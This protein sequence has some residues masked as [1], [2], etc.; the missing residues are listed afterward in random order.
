MVYAVIAILCFGVLIATHE[1]GHMF[2]AKACGVKVNE[3]AI[4]MGP[5]LWSKQKGETK[6]S[7]RLFPVGGYCAIEGESGESDDPRSLCSQSVLKQIFVFSAGV[8]VNFLTGFLILV[9]IYAGADFLITPEIVS[10][11]DGFPYAGEAG[12]MVGDTIKE[13][14]GSSVYLYSD[15]SVILMATDAGPN[16]RISMVVERDGELLE[17]QL[18]KTTYTEADGSETVAYG[19]VYGG[20]TPATLDMKLKY[21]FLNTIDFVRL[22]GFNFKIIAKGTAGVDDLRGPVGI[23]SE[24]TKMGNEAEATS[25]FADAFADVLYYVAMIAINL[26]VMNLLPIPALDGGHIVVLLLDTVVMKLFSR[27][28]SQKAINAVTLGSFAL[29]LLLMLVISYQD[30]MRLIPR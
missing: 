20:V 4:G 12:I 18:E 6:Y 25:G 5:A 21:T 1:V 2:A 3:Y 24:I 26:A 10:L 8:L 22:V 13:I 23:V 29:V 30:V 16:G 14:N 17:R 9:F 27:R 11:R 15:I 28:I 7:L 19:F